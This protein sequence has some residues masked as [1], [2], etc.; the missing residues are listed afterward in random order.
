MSNFSIKLKELREEKNLS[1]SD[2]GK[3]LEVS[4]AAICK[5]EN[6]V[7]EP[8]I[9][10][11]K[12][13]A[14]FFDVSCDYL[15]DLAPDEKPYRPVI[16]QNTFSL[17]EDEKELVDAFRRMTKETQAITLDTVHSLAGDNERSK[18]VLNKR[19]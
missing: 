14:L 2:L 17:S 6:S 3:L 10:Y 9:S 11:L 13:I 8:K 19:A 5:W 4:D 12:K 18:G 16:H 1:M 15:L 7:N